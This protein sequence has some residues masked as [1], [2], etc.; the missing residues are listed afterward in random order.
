MR[1]YVIVDGYLISSDAAQQ[2]AAWRARQRLHNEICAALQ[3]QRPVHEITTE[4][5]ITVRAKECY[6]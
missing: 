1:R 2:L 4:D 5:A 6:L 3:Q